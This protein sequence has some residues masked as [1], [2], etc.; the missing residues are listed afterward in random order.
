VPGA[1]RA[2]LGHRHLEVREHL[3]QERLELGL[4]LV[5]LVHEQHHGLVGED[6][7]EQ[8]A[9]REEAEREERVLLPRDLGDRVRQRGGVGEQLADPL[10]QE[11]R[12]EELLGV[13]PLVEGLALVQALVALEPD[14]RAARDVGQRLGQLRLADAR[15]ALDEHRP[16]HARRQVHDRGHPAARDVPRVPEPL[17][18]LLDGLEHSVPLCG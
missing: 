5:D 4:G 11:L 14:Q 8:R 6:R 2:E 10:A 1:H 7:L 16:A 9:R 15:R 3:E 17:L 13:L 18:D 12:V